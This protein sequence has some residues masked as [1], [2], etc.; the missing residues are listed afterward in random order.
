ML[1]KLTDWE[2][3]QQKEYSL[4][5]K[6]TEK[7]LEALEK[8]NRKDGELGLAT[9]SMLF[10][11]EETSVKEEVPSLQKLKDL[12]KNCKTSQLLLALSI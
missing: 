1:G 2:T 10:A 6:L 12:S 3:K 8:A 4:K 11:G 5:A 9:P 7:N